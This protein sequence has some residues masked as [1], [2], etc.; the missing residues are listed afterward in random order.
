MSLATWLCFS[1][2]NQFCIGCLDTLDLFTGWLLGCLVA[3]LLAWSV[4]SD[5]KTSS[6]GGS[7]AD[8]ESGTETADD[9]SGSASQ[10]GL[11]GIEEKSV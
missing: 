2:I 11:R 3:W 9:P 5:V 1:S 7:S 4:G 10:R 6:G 8:N